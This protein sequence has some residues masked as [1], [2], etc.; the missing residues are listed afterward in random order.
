ML[1]V[2]VK[3]WGFFRLISCSGGRTVSDIAV[4]SAIVESIPRHDTKPLA[5]YSN[6]SSFKHVEVF[7]TQLGK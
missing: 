6:N 1:A 7:Q 5:A 3:G 4:S 2:T